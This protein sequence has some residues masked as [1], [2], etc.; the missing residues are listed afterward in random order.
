MKVLFITRGYPSP[1]DPMAGN[2]EAVQARAIAAKGHEVSV[3]G[4]KWRSV[5][6]LLECRKV[7]HRVDIGIQVYTCVRVMNAVREI[8]LFPK[9]LLPIITFSIHKKAFEKVFKLY[10]EENGMPDI[11]HIHSL[12]AAPAV[13]ALKE[14][15]NIPVVITEHWSKVLHDN[16]PDGFRRKIDYWG[17]ICYPLAD[18]VIAVS[19]ALANA[20]NKRFGVRCGVINNMVEK[21]F[22]RTA[23]SGNPHKGFR[24]ISVGSLFAIKGYDTLIEAFSKLSDDV[25]VSL[26]IVGKGTEYD[27]LQRLINDRGQQKRI[28]LAGVKPPE[29]VARMLENADCFVLASRSETF[30]I[31][32]IEAMAKGLPVIA[33]RCG[34]PE[35]IVNKEYG[36]LVD[37]GDIDGLANAL[38]FMIKHKAT[39]DKDKIRKFCYDNYSENVIADKIVGVYKE[40]I[41]NRL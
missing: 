14:H 17:K 21:R 1:E 3:I 38:E 6:H 24:F 10:V 27:S 37:V 23:I 22:F 9:N 31:V 33:T 12:H 2:Y 11:V 36:K 34:G 39:F 13:A 35:E 40:L 25:D 7:Q 18:S 20:I 19:D 16:I 8:P 5:L 32:F 29:E 41:N 4:I 26:D 15:T 28:R 30:G